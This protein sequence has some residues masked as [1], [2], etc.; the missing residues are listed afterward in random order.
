MY[1]CP[2]CPKTNRFK[3]ACEQNTTVEV[4][5]DSNGTIHATQ[6]ASTFVMVSAHDLMK[7]DLCGMDA[8]SIYFQ[9]CHK[10]QINDKQHIAWRFKQPVEVQNFGLYRNGVLVRAVG[11]ERWINTNNGEWIS[12]LTVEYKLINSWNP[13]RDILRGMNYNDVYPELTPLPKNPIRLYGGQ[14]PLE[15]TASAEK[16]MALI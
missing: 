11:Y 16:Q 3:A 15:R 1:R 12:T 13:D 8:E 10:M 7:C 2:K 14:G 6:L 4:D 9:H 5:L